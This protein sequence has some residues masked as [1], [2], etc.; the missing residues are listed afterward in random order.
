MYLDNEK[1]GE[2]RVEK[3]VPV[4]FS[5]DETLDVGRESGSPVSPEY[6]S[7]D[8]AFTGEVNWISIDARGVDYDREVPAGDRFQ[9]AMAWE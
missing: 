6:D 1:I 5:I 4:A 9:A 8:N 2:G 3:T 7:R